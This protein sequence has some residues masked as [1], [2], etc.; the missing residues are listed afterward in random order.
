MPLMISS[1]KSHTIAFV[2][3]YSLEAGHQASPHS[4]GGEQSATSW[5]EKPQMICG[6]G[7]SAAG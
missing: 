3:M 7:A 4:Q 5:K 2:T 1:L 6:V